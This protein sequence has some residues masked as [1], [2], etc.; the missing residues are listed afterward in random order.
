MPVVPVVHV[1]GHLFDCLYQVVKHVVAAVFMICS[2]VGLLKHVR[3]RQRAGPSALLFN[4]EVWAFHKAVCFANKL[5][6]QAQF[7]CEHRN[8]TITSIHPR[9]YV[10]ATNSDGCSGLPLPIPARVGSAQAANRDD[11]RPHHVI[12]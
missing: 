12:A 2:V 3:P 9:C 1:R 6:L 11:G 4:K 7:V 10:D 5:T 8:L